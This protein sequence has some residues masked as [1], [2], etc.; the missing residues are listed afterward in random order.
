MFRTF[1][2]VGYVRCVPWRIIF[3]VT[4]LL[5]ATIAKQISRFPTNILTQLIAIQVWHSKYSDEFLYFWSGL[6]QNVPRK[7]DEFALDHIGCMTNS[8]NQWSSLPYLGREKFHDST[9]LP[10]SVDWVTRLG[11][12][13]CYSDSSDTVDG[14]NPAPVDR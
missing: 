14:W 10:K 12:Y 7:Q 3:G 13:I 6:H 8:E 1:R 9:V 11:C 4:F 2:L 5:V